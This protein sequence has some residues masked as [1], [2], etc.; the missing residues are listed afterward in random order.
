MTIELS[1][2]S[3]VDLAYHV[4]S[5]LDL[6]RDAASL[7]RA[8]RPEPSWAPALLAA[9]H[10]SPGRLWAHFAPLQSDSIDGL[11]RKIPDEALR[12]AMA[13]ALE[14]ER[15]GF[16][17]RWQ[18]ERSAR[19]VVLEQAERELL[20]RLGALRE[21]LWEDLDQAAPT[22]QLLH[23]PALGRHARAG[24]LRGA[25]RVATSLAEPVEP[26][27][28]QVFHEECHP[29]TDPQ[30]AAT[31]SVADRDTRAGAANYEAHMALER[32]AVEHGRLVIARV[33]P[34]LSSSY[35]RWCARFGIGLPSC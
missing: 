14:L 4:L 2:S 35:A 28:C 18:A 7:Y 32:A 16:E 23:T 11:L 13:R 20:D 24:W 5:H 27:L 31:R 33:M 30:V 25:R 21:A 8:G 15:P 9:Y 17:A 1:A 34:G 22:L 10:A 6:G 29:I 19:A 26:T 12:A 3:H